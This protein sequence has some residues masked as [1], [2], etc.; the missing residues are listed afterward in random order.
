MMSR[1]KDCPYC[2]DNVP[3]A[4][5]DARCAVCGRAFAAY[6]VPPAD[7]GVRECADCRAKRLEAQLF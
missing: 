7:D 4:R 1:R 2:R 3:H 6:H 5:A